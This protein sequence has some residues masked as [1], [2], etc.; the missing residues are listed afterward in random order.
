MIHKLRKGER[1]EAFVMQFT[2]HSAHEGKL[3]NFTS[4]WQAGLTT[5]RDPHTSLRQMWRKRPEQSGS[6]RG[7]NQK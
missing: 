7:S 6:T 5:N 3:L 2:G 1:A 4:S